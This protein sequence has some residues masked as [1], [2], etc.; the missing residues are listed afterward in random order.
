ML[1]LPQLFSARFLKQRINLNVGLIN[2]GRARERERAGKGRRL[3]NSSSAF[4]RKNKNGF[5]R[6]AALEISY[7]RVHF[8]RWTH[9]RSERKENTRETK[10]REKIESLLLARLSKFVRRFYASTEKPAVLTFN[11]SV[12]GLIDCRRRVISAGREL[13]N[14]AVCVAAR[15]VYGAKICKC[16]GNAWRGAGVAF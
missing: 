5:I 6:S 7:T 3:G 16:T 2:V 11:G 12:K 4:N 14:P 13:E 8:H 1:F 15:F 9:S 10:K